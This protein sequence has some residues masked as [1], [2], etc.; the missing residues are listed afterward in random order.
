MQWEEPLMEAH[1]DVLTG[2]LASFGDFPENSQGLGAGA[3][4]NVGFGM[5]IIDTALQSR[6]PTHHTIIEAHPQ[7]YAKMVADGWTEK[8]NVTVLFGKW[9]DVIHE[10]GKFDGVFF[11]TYGEYYEDMHNFHELLPNLLNPG[12]IYSFFNGMCPFNIF[13]HGVACELV[14]LELQAIGLV[15]HFVP[16][17]IQLDPATWQ[18]VRRKYWQRETYYLPIC[19]NTRSTGGG[20]L[21]GALDEV[22]TTTAPPAEMGQQQQQQRASVNPPAESDMGFSSSSSSSMTSPSLQRS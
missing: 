11:D 14:R 5:G 13:F 9:Q 22:A 4:L 1:A 8:E 16:I 20:G 18:G 12:G 10:A 7:V 19:L 3:V 15:S 2:Q 21:G 17:Q 6:N